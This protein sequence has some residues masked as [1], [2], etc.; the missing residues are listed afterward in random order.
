[1]HQDNDI[2]TVAEK[3]PHLLENGHSPLSEFFFLQLSEELVGK[4]QRE[5]VQ[6]YV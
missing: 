6:C 1:M 2:K 3:I 4:C 5:P